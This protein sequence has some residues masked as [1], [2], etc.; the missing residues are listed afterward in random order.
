MFVVV[1][2]VKRLFVSPKRSLQRLAAL[3]A[4]VLVFKCLLQIIYLLEA[5]LSASESEVVSEHANDAIKDVDEQVG[6][7]VGETKS[8]LATVSGV[9]DL[10]PN[11]TSVS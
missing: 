8:T 3:C 4:V 9:D 6:L 11:Q 5:A 2:R 1:R 7:I 10:V